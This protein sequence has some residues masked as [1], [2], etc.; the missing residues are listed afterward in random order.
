MI[1]KARKID[2]IERSRQLYED[3]GET[4]PTNLTKH[5]IAADAEENPA[6]AAFLRK[7]ELNRLR[8]AAGIRRR[9]A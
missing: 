4:Y 2:K 6:R 3:G 1:R 8:A 7:Q 5:M 9:R